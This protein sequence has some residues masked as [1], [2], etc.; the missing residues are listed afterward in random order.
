MREGEGDR[1][2][3]LGDTMWSGGRM[4]D[5][6]DGERQDLGFIWSRREAPNGWLWRGGWCVFGCGCVKGRVEWR[7][8]D[9]HTNLA[10]QGPDEKGWALLLLVC[11][12]SAGSAERRAQKQQSAK[13]LACDL[14]RANVAVEHQ[15]R[16][17]VSF[18]SREPT[19]W[20]ST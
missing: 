17:D 13:R 7:S 10:V 19:G 11:W 1:Q 9:Q 2:C 16:S 3:I 5:Q 8:R 14:G 6:A 20:S 15:S 4:R 12:G 18:S